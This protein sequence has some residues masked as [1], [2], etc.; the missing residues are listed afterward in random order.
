MK[1]SLVKLMCSPRW[2]KTFI[3][4]PTLPWVEQP[5]VVKEQRYL[6]PTLKSN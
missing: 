5:F 1:V 3:D 4:W 2:G 6:K